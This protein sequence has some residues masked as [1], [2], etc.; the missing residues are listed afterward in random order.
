VS[1]SPGWV[2]TLFTLSVGLTT[3]AQPGLPNVAPPV[4]RLELPAPPGELELRLAPSRPTTVLLNAALDRAAMERVAQQPGL[5]RVEV[6]ES[7]LVLLPAPGVKPGTRLQ[8][9]LRF[10][11]GQP[12]E[13]VPLVLVVD[14]PGAEAYVEVVRRERTV[15]ALEATLGA[16]RARCAAMEV[17]LATLREGAALLT[18]LV[19]AGTLGREG[20]RV[21]ELNL[22][23]LTPPPGLTA[24][25]PRL[26]IATGRL[27]VEVELTLAE[28]A[29]PWT[30]GTATLHDRVNRAAPIFARSVRW[31][32]APG[33]VP[34]GKARLLVEFEVSTADPNGSFDL[35]VP[36]QKGE[37]VLKLQDLTST[38]R[39]TRKQR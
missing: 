36:E 31:L 5:V 38:S 28:D 15:A 26:Y 34:G 27:A 3:M 4:R 25:H 39:P 24:R 2:V 6:A 35:K 9:T 30:P 12:P 22:T 32:E 29:R 7:A 17:E 10:A 37:R 21:V 20:I 14:S 18:P 1:L 23:T 33:L 16:E 11:D 13:G 19:M 8:L